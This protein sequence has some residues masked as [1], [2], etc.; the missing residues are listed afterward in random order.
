MTN[1]ATHRQRPMTSTQLKELRDTLARE[2]GRFGPGDPRADVF[3][4]ALGRIENGT[5][6]YCVTCSNLIP[7]DRLEVV[8]ETVY[9]VSCRRISA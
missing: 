2:A 8:P 7:H 1:I 4:A 5:Y 3:L 9:C 6:G